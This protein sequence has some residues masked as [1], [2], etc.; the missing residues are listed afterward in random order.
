M[1]KDMTDIDSIYHNLTPDE[2]W[3]LGKDETPTK[4]NWT[5]A[6]HAEFE[7]LC[8]LQEVTD[9]E[10]DVLRLILHQPHQAAL[11][12]ILIYCNALKIDPHTFLES[13]LT[14][15]VVKASFLQA[16]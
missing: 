5:A 16:A 9:L 2:L 12:D 4:V 11:G 1:I 13:T 7:Q 15:T 10:F 6:E 14:K 3:A 8:A